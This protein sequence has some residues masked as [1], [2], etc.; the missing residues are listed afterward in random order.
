MRKPKL[1]V[2][3][4]AVQIVKKTKSRYEL[5]NEKRRNQLSDLYEEVMNYYPK[6]EADWDSVLKVNYANQIEQTVV[7]R[8]TA[9]APRF[10]VS[11]KDSAR[12]IAKM[13]Y[14]AKD[15]NS[16][17]FL[18]M[19]K[20]VEGWGESIQD[21]LNT[22]FDSYNYR[23]SVN[24][25]VKSLIR[26]GNTYATVQYHVDT[27]ATYRE[28]KV[29]RTNADEYPKLENISWK[30]IY[31][32]P[33]FK[34][35]SD[36]PAVIYSKQNVRLSELYSF[37][38]LFNLD[39]IKEVRTSS[40]NNKDSAIYSLFITDANSNDDNN[41]QVSNLI[42]DQYFG[43]FSTTGEV[44]D[45]KLYEIW[46]VNGSVCI[47]LKEIPKIPVESAVCFEDPEQHYGIGYV[48]PIL[49]L[50]REYNFKMNSAIQYVN[51]NLNHSWFWDAKSGIDPKELANASAPGAIIVA[52]NGVENA[53]AGLREIPKASI[54]PSYFSQQNTIKADI[55]TLSF[56][57]DPSNPLNRAGSTDTATAVRVKFFES[58]SVYADTLRRVEELLVR[59]AYNILDCVAL[60]AKNDVIV[61]HLNNGNYK[62]ANPEI[63]K[64]SPLRYAIQVEVGS[65]SFDSIE[66]R[67]ED[68]LAKIAV[69]E[70]AVAAGVEVDLTE[71][72]KDI[73]GTFE[74][75]DPNKYIKKNVDMAGIVGAK[76]NLNEAL[77]GN[78]NPLGDIEQLVGQVAQGN[79]ESNV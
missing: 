52:N 23:Q 63:F 21:Y 35:T 25:I 71:G 11:I 14:P 22:L 76:T 64:D 70:R 60:N 41:K 20:Q 66:N 10:I 7:S 72:F 4:R 5:K 44:K 13:Y 69:L 6:K 16:A 28:G 77:P 15:E 61:K 54:D 34:Q 24:T 78:T 19:I 30:D 36:S 17:E 43:Y 38:D 42:V 74:G 65:S 32:D 73:L 49:G 50:Q 48:E 39:K 67:R 29:S 9:R 12:K 37:D 55:Q 45:E 8:L 27:Y 79:I 2:L 56:T 53:L 68:A 3:N 57:S 18:A 1:E 51:T 75:V 47:K 33:R 62:W 40:D 59:I 31:I 58:S 26:Y 46:T